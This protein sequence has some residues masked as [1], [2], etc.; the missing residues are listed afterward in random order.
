MMEDDSRSR[1]AR[2]VA[3]LMDAGS[4]ALGKLLEQARQLDEINRQLERFFGLV[5]DE[6]PK[7]ASIGGGRLRVLARNGAQASMLKLQ[8][9]ECLSHL[10]QQGM[11][12]EGIDV[13]VE[14]SLAS[15]RNPRQR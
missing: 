2:S 8:A 13:R 14:P 9:A 7:A 11:I 3:Q 15:I 1:S 12:L 10:A 5:P 6:A 4:P